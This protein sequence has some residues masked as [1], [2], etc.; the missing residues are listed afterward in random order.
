MTKRSK[1]IKKAIENKQYDIL[2][3]I[4]YINYA[5]Q[6][7]AE[8]GHLDVVK[9]LI[10]AGADVRADNDIAFLW[11]VENVH[12]DIIKYFIKAGANVHA[13]ED[14][15]LLYAAKNGY[16]EIV[17]CLV[18]AGA[19]IHVYNDFALRYAAWHG[20][21]NIV[22]YLIDHGAN[23][24]AGNDDILKCAVRNDFL[25]MI[26]ILVNEVNFHTWNKKI[27]Y[28]II[29]YKNINKNIIK[30]LKYLP[31]KILY[32]KISACCKIQKWYRQYLIKKYNPD[33]NYVKNDIK[34]RFES[35]Q[36]NILF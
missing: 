20:Y 2:T 12:L 18:E 17:E 4:E 10:E 15:S 9:Y 11:A 29:K 33:S 22:K 16:L 24:H 34:P 8:R 23:I 3:K 19:N 26:K 5:L 28:S 36:M 30:Y 31:I 13:D 1:I 35:M 14:Y 21:L 27:I 7:A 25:D 6:Y 32:I